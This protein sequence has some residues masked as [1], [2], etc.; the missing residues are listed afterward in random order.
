MIDNDQML[1]AGV[2]ADELDT[3]VNVSEDGSE[4][5]ENL[6]DVID[7]E[8]LDD[9]SWEDD[10]QDDDQ[11]EDDG[12]SDGKKP[13]KNREK[14]LHAAITN[15]NKTIK[16]LQEENKLLKKAQ[17][18]IMSKEEEKQIEELKEKYGEDDL[19]VIQSL[20]KKEAAAEIKK[21]KEAKLQQRELNI[22]LKKYPEISEPELKHI[23]YLQSQFWYSLEKAYK[24]IWG[25]VESKQKS[26]KTANH[27]IWSS[28][29]SWTKG[30]NQD[31]SDEAAFQD[32]VNNYVN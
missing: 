9:D 16:E 32:M 17:E 11:G 22:F 1:T 20:A 24:Q 27:S 2:S 3:G 8:D 23:Q 10:D 12:Q 6:E 31:D 21:Q 14:R 25:I 15:A 5:D 18:T 7:E 30:S 19:E 13:K 4:I 28:M 26:T 29:K